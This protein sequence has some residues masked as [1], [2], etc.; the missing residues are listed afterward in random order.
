[1]QDVAGLIGVGL[2][3]TLIGMAVVFALL[4]ILVGLV[5]AVSA[6]CQWIEKPLTLQAGDS[7]DD[8]EIVSVISAAI[9]QYRKTNAPST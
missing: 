9:E 5:N 7:T 8:N 3:V 4:T 1:M 2:Q 6:F